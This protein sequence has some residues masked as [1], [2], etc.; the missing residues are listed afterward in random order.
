M[1]KF[2][3]QAGMHWHFPCL[4]RMN[5][6]RMTLEGEDL[7]E[8]ICITGDRN[9]ESVGA[10]ELKD[11]KRKRK[12]RLGNQSP[13]QEKS[14]DKVPEILYTIYCLRDHT[15]VHKRGK[16]LHIHYMNMDSANKP[17]P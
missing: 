13:G 4:P 12:V 17:S 15:F 6:M 10:K 7:K 2:S 9:K 1:Q 14:K 3:V 5:P 8:V 11:H 16:N